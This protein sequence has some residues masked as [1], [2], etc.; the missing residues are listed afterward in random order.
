MQVDSFCKLLSD[1]SME[2]RTTH[3]KVLARL[4]RKKHERERKKTKGKLIVSQFLYSAA[5]H[6]IVEDLPLLEH[7]WRPCLAAKHDSSLEKNNR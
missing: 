7:T 3:G 5:L 6:T 4:E 1:F 2:Y